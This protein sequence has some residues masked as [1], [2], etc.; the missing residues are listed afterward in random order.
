MKV[1]LIDTGIHSKNRNALFKYNNIQITYIN[2][3][4][5]S[6]MNLNMFDIVYSPSSPIN[7]ENYPNTKFIFG[8]HFS[9][10]P[11]KH[12]IEIISKN[13]N[14][15]YVQPSDWVVDLWKSFPFFNINIK[16][17]PFGVDTDKF[18][19]IKQNS[20]RNEIFVYFK[21]RNN[22]ELEFIL[23]FFKSKKIDYK[24]FDYVKKYNE[25]E[26][27]NCLQ[28]SK[29][30]IWLDA[31]ESQG[32]ALQE[33]LSC[34]VPLLVWNVSSLNQ[35][36]GS[37]YPNFYATT[38]SYWNDNCGEIFY[39]YDEFLDKFNSFIS[40][41]DTYTPRQFILNNLSIKKCE[42]KFINLVNNI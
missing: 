33:A 38:L 27:L 3:T 21:R 15:V 12:S 22:D 36:V 11:E 23:N 7:V 39:N 8:P 31:H 30:G 1:L 34:N 14:V 4:N 18:N 28:N 24:L 26:Y 42:E 20:Q 41:L 40:K 35:E 19:E 6:S 16:S 9:V 2:H 10:F 25:I 17:L 13:K 32:F 37:N 5:I 29:Y